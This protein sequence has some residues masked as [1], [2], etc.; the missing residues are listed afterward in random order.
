VARNQKRGSKI[1]KIELT[2]ILFSVFLLALVIIAG[3]VVGGAQQFTLLAKAF[4]HGQLN[5]LHPIGGRGYDPILY[6]GKIFWSEGPFPA[7]LL[8]PFILIAELFHVF[9][10][11]G[12][13]QWVLILGIFYF[14]YSLAR[15][16]KYSK[17]DSIYLILAFGLGSV[18][19]GIES[20]SSSWMFAQVV[21]TFL[22]FWSLYEFYVVKKRRWWM[23]GIISGLILLTRATASPIII[24][25]FLI[26]WLEDESKDKRSKYIQL[27]LPFGIAIFLVGLYNYLRFGNATNGG[28]AY[29][30]LFP[31]SAASR[32]L[33]IF[34]IQHI[35]TNLYYML[36]GSPNVA[37]L[38]SAS[39]T[40]KF[41]YIG[42][43]NNG[44]SIFLT[45]P[46]LLTLF[47]NKWSSF[48]AQ[49]RYLLTATLI[50]II[51]V[52]SYYGIGRNQFGY[53]Y[54]L[55]FLPE[56]FVLFMIM[57]KKK[58]KVI[59]RGMKILILGSG[60]FNFYLL[61]TVL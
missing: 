26:L 37:Q 48:K 6:K 27:L 14:I 24:F 17:K 52:L 61:N 31:Q 35:P 16:F 25:F 55:D 4:L 51:F 13:L 49:E 46:Y 10:D 50:S 45:S 44:L 56:L 8:I 22:L 54:S 11:Q 41:P 1:N 18:F 3:V 39:W 60:Y 59:S 43:N 29:Q 47:T 42:S 23:L 19:I 5:F 15:K 34:S 36:L 30:V 40:L 38:S 58:N 12:Y 20:F 33:G 53:R 7:I 32:A 9:F 21:T 28:F 57:Y 2:L